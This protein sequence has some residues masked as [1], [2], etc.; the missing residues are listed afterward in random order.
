MGIIDDLLGSE[1]NL[2]FFISVAVWILIF[3]YLFFLNDKFKNLKRE[4]D[5][6]KDE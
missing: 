6:L 3:V 1:L 4:L 2:L 5:T